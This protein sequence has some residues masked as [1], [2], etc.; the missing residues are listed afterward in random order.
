[1]K[2]LWQPNKTK[3]EVLFQEAVTANQRLPPIY[4]K[5]QY[6]Y[7]MIQKVIVYY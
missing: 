5:I 4:S 1:M 3:Q 6:D 2:N 7:T